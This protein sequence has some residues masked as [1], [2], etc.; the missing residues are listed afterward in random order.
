MRL[1]YRAQLKNPLPRQLQT[2][3]PTQRACKRFKA[4]VFSLDVDWR[5]VIVPHADRARCCGC[6]LRP[7]RFTSCRCGWSDWFSRAI[8][9]SF[10]D[11]GCEALILGRLPVVRDWIEA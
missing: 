11:V 4:L 10:P 9:P 2:I 8:M 7:R 1:Q 5:V 3:R 6:I